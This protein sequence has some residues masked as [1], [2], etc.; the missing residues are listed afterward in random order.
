LTKGKKGFEAY[1]NLLST[2]FRIDVLILPPS[3][4]PRSPEFGEELV[5]GKYFEE[6]SLPL[7][8]IDA[9]DPEGLCRVWGEKGP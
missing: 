5:F 6:F 3:Q 2:M 9:V 8:S 1:G 7:L 4:L